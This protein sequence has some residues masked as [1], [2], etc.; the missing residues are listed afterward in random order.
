MSM[1]RARSRKAVLLRSCAKTK[2]ELGNDPRRA[3]NRVRVRHMA[4]STEKAYVNIEV[5]KTEPAPIV[6]T[7]ASPVFHAGCH[8]FR[9]SFAAHV[10]RLNGFAVQSSVDRYW[11]AALRQRSEAEARSARQA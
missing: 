5:M 10:L 2:S 1:M 3:G 8:T 11:S 9:H 4:R 6:V 7:G